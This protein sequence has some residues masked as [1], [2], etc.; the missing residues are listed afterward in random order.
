MKLFL[1]L[2][3]F[4]EEK[5]PGFGTKISNEHGHISVITDNPHSLCKHIITDFV[6]DETKRGQGHGDILIK[7]VIRRYKHDIGGQASSKGSVAV[8]Y[9]NGFRP[10]IKIDGSL[11]DA[12]EIMAEW[13]SV[14]MVYKPA[15]TYKE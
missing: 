3:S 6:I 15:K 13:S 1:A 10:F 12:F 4:K 5:V 2:A 9:K 14:L 11:Q 8:M 7:E